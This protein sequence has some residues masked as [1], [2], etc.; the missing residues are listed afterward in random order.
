MPQIDGV[1]YEVISADPYKYRCAW[2]DRFALAN[3]VLHRWRSEKLQVVVG[4]VGEQLLSR[5]GGIDTYKT[6]VL[7]VRTSRSSFI[8]DLKFDMTEAIRKEL[9]ESK[10]NFSF[11]FTDDC[12]SE[13]G[14]LISKPSDLET[15]QET[16]RDRKSLL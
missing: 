3:I 5:E 13:S 6:V 15:K 12:F 10:W 2:D 16:W 8:D 14:K 1:P 4:F 7:T 9:R 11:K